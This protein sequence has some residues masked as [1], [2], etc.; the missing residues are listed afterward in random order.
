M[1]KSEQVYFIGKYQYLRLEE[2][3]TS[4][5][6]WMILSRI[7]TQPKSI[8]YDAEKSFPFQVDDFIKRIQDLTEHEDFSCTI[9]SEDCKFQFH[10]QG[11]R[12][13]CRN[14]ISKEIFLKYESLI[15]DYLYP[16]MENDG[17]YGY[18]RSYDDYLYNNVFLLEERYFED[19]EEQEKLPKMYNEE[20]KVVV[21]C[22][23][24]PGFDLYYKNLLLTSCWKMFFGKEYY[25]LLPKKVLESVQRIYSISEMQN[26]MLQITLYKNLFKWDLPVNI[27]YQRFFRDQV[28]FDQLAWEN[29]VGLLRPPL[30]EFAFEEDC[31]HTV[32]ILV[33]LVNPF[34]R[35]WR[36]VLSHGL[37]IIK[38]KNVTNTR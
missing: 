35:S 37:I 38:P 26:E 4:L 9:T 22:N 6:D 11:F 3:Q 5:L 24:L 21:D 2:L 17:I 25:N 32:S 27:G 31:I 34:R 23:Q 28:G 29:G 20:R 19:L 33:E 15:E 16:R 18:M 30:I 8:Q 10:V 36:R 7:V 14:L 13:F 12:L 1:E